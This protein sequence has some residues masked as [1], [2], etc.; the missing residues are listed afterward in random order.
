MYTQQPKRGAYVKRSIA[1]GKGSFM[2]SYRTVDYKDLACLLSKT[3]EERMMTKG[4]FVQLEMSDKS[5]GQYK[6]RRLLLPHIS[7]VHTQANLNSSLGIMT[8]DHNLQGKY[9]ICVSLQ[10]SATVKF[11]RNSFEAAL[12]RSEQ[13]GIYIAD[14]AYNFMVSKD[15]NNIH[16]AIDREY[17]IN[18]LDEGEEWSQQL[19]GR[20]CREDMLYSGSVGVSRHME[21]VLADRQSVE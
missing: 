7:I 6:E 14:S 2:T 5:L 17:Y 9:N 18:L 16:F 19:R 10:G 11:R 12:T 20:L 3:P 21:R 13:H 4:E 8:E 1:Y 15:V